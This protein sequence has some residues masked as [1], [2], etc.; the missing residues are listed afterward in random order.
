MSVLGR[1]SCFLHF[2]V[3]EFLDEFLQVTIELVHAVGRY[4]DLEAGV[5]AG[6]GLGN[7]EKAATRVLLQ[8]DVILLVVLEE[9][10]GAEFALDELARVDRAELAVVFDHGDKVLAKLGRRGQ[11][12]QD[13]ILAAIG[14]DLGDLDEAPAGVFFHI[15]VE[16]FVLEDKRSGGEI[17]ATAGSVNILGTGFG[18]RHVVKSASLPLALVPAVPVIEVFGA[19]VVKA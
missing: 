15:Q 10:L 6:E 7:L 4:E 14:A 2:A 18:P 13:L 11:R 12:H 5:A 16:P 1:V 17:T 3:V 19:G 8:I 9:H